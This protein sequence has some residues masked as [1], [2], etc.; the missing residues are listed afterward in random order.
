[1]VVSLLTDNNLCLKDVMTNTSIR[2][3]FCERLMIPIW[4]TV[5]LDPSGKVIDIDFFGCLEDVIG[6]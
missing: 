3:K 1:M 5:Y 4:V 2:E 6:E